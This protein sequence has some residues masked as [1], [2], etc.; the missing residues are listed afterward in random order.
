LAEALRQVPVDSVESTAVSLRTKKPALTA[1]ATD[2][3]SSTLVE[4]RLSELDALWS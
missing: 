4:P 3:K 1:Q 2:E